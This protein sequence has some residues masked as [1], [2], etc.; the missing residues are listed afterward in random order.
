MLTVNSSEATDQPFRQYNKTFSGLSGSIG[1]TYKLSE[2][3]TLKSNVARGFRAPNISELSANGVHP[4][5]RIYQI[6]NE[7]FKPEFSLQEDIGLSF[8]CIKA[9]IGKSGDLQQQY[10]Q[11]HL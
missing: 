4:G 1:A 5:T 8:L 7:E 9:C 2:F 6:G 3:F 11:L 10:H